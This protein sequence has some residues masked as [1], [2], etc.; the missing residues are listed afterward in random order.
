M[1]LYPI[2]SLGPGR[3][4]GIWVQGCERTCPGCANPE[5]QAMGKKE[6]PD[7]ML[8]GMAVAAFKSYH[9]DGITLT[10]GEPVLQAG[11]LAR[12]LAALEPYCDDVL[13]FSGFTLRELQDK[14]DPEVDSLLA[15][16][17]VLV[18]GPYIQER[19]ESELLRGSSNQTIHYL[20]S[21]ARPRYETYLAQ[22]RH[23]IDSFIAEDGVVSVGIHP[24]GFL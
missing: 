10:G 4:M 1:V 20:N 23:I 6:I 18:D 15:R 22:G 19:N 14:Q 24:K 9:L 11:A 7:E 5:L 21:G 3:R 2:Q 12:L 16:V 17:S 13:M 8:I